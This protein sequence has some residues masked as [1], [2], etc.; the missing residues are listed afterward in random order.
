MKLLG[1]I[2]LAVALAGVVA[3]I[4]IYRTK[5][6]KEEEYENYDDVDEIEL[7]NRKIEEMEGSS[8]SENDDDEEESITLEEEVRKYASDNP[9]RVTDLIN[10]W[11]NV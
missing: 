2:L 9:D 5:K 6:K 11:L 1:F 4:V 3:F 8:K 7:I 10:S